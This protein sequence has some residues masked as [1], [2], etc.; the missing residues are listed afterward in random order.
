MNLRTNIKTQTQCFLEFHGC[1]FD[2]VS[3]L[4]LSNIWKSDKQLFDEYAMEAL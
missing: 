2:V 4:Y 1:N 3:N